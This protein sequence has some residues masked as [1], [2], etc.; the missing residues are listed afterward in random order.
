MNSSWGFGNRPTMPGREGELETWQGKTFTSQAWMFCLKPEWKA[1]FSSAFKTSRNPYICPTFHHEIV[2]FLT[3]VWAQHSSLCADLA[4]ETPHNSSALNTAA[5]YESSSFALCLI[6]PWTSFYTFVLREGIDIPYPLLRH[7]AAHPGNYGQ[8]CR[9]QGSNKEECEWRQ[10]MGWALGAL[11]QRTRY[12]GFVGAVKSISADFS[13][14][15]GAE[16]AGTAL[17]PGPRCVLESDGVSPAYGMSKHHMVCAGTAGPPCRL[18]SVKAGRRTFTFPLFAVYPFFYFPCQKP[19]QAK[20]CSASIVVLLLV[21]YVSFPKSLLWRYPRNSGESIY[22]LLL[23]GSVKKCTILLNRQAL[24]WKSELASRRCRERIQLEFE[25]WGCLCKSSCWKCLFVSQVSRSAIT[26]DTWKLS[27]SRGFSAPVA[28]ARCIGNE[29]QSW[30]QNCILWSCKNI[31]K[32]LGTSDDWILCFFESLFL[33][34]SSLL[35]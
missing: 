23:K 32:D 21:T 26:T 29:W 13:G 1:N 6:K 20:S 24:I 2:S 35:D 4:G 7:S 10:V 3:P 33:K 16:E 27:I 11:W 25:V 28:R 22:M 31:F 14:R 8:V 18:R 34:E 5:C 15:A 12:C 30:K 17:L 9:Y 19:K